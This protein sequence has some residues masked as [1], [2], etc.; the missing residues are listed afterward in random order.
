MTAAPLRLFGGKTEEEEEEEA[1]PVA[2]PSISSLPSREANPYARVPGESA[3]HTLTHTPHTQRRM[4]HTQSTHRAHTEHTCT[5][6]P[7]AAS[8]PQLYPGADICR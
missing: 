3:E 7:N 4:Q 5:A 2:P 6:A 1:K 8:H